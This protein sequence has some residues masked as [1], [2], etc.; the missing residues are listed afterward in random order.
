MDLPSFN[1][2]VSY[3]AGI[4]RIINHAMN[5][6]NRMKINTDENKRQNINIQSWKSF[7]GK[8]TKRKLFCSHLY[9]CQLHGI[10]NVARN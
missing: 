9:G 3:F 4:P 5:Q 2:V 7:M 8:K 1:Y 10:L 6:N